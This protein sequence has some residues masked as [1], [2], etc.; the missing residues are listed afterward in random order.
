[1]QTGLQV[2]W[3]AVLLSG[4]V[5]SLD[6]FRSFMLYDWYIVCSEDMNS[7]VIFFALS[8]VFFSF[9]YFFCGTLNVGDDR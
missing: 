3:V 7:R 5:R 2:T 4:A 8:G 1:M 9:G 6:V